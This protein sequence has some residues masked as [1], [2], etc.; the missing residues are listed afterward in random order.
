MYLGLLKL[1]YKAE[2]AKAEV[3]IDFAL[4]NVGASSFDSV[5]K[6]FDSLVSCRCALD[7]IDAIETKAKD[8][9]SKET[10]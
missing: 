2:L 1:H 8:D 6:N 10:K 5:K 3:Q 7:M 4:Q 9:S